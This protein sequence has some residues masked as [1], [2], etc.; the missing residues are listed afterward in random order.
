MTFVRTNLTAKQVVCKINRA[1]LAQKCVCRGENIVCEI[2]PERPWTAVLGGCRCG[3]AGM[4]C[5]F[6][7]PPRENTEAESAALWDDEQ[8]R[9]AALDDEAD[10]GWRD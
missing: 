7:N 2:H 9:K 6:C 1:M 5:P 8:A 10:G 4:P 3:G